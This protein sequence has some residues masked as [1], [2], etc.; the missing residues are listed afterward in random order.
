MG[1]FL[2]TLDRP[3]SFLSALKCDIYYLTVVP[4][5]FVCTGG[6]GDGNS[7]VSINMSDGMVGTLLS[8]LFALSVSGP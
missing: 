4:L 8:W 1:Y 3:V 2:F 5:E 6:D 7:N